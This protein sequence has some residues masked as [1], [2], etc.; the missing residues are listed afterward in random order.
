MAL[1]EQQADNTVEKILVGTMKALSRRGTHKLSVSDICE[2]S[3]VARGTFY[4]YFTS[5]EDV[6]AALTRHFEGG[7][8]TAFAAAIEVNPDPAARVQVVLDTIIAYHAAGGDL[9]RML[10]VAPSFTLEF[11]R[12]TFPN[13]VDVVTDALGPAAEES[14]LVTAGALTKRQLGDLFL[15]S[16][17]SML[18]LPGDSSLEVPAVVASLFRAESMAGTSRRRKRRTA[19]K[20]S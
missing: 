13:L 11:I 9:V 17:V 20:A 6:L 10:D 1:D 15:R 3:G 14:P 4:R 18:F 12:D 2:S 19:A 5:K 7:V 16:I 8:A